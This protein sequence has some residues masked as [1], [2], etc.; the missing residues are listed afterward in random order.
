MSVDVLPHVTLRVERIEGHAA[1]VAFAFE[2]PDAARAAPDHAVVLQAGDDVALAGRMIGD[3]VRLD[4]RQP[5]VARGKKPTCF[6]GR[7]GSEHA[8]VAG[9]QSRS[10]PL[11]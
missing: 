4:D 2:L 3:V 9:G 10:P 7:I 5:V 8:T 1:A 6:V 11:E